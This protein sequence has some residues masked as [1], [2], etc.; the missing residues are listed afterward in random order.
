MSALTRTAFSGEPAAFEYL[1]NTLW[2][3]G[4]V[5]PHCGSI[6]RAT[7][8]QGRNGEGKR[9]ARIGLWKCN[10][11]E[12]RK[13][14]T[15]KVGTVFE[16]GRIPLHKMLQAVYLLCCSKKGISSHQ[17]HRVLGITYK[18]AWFLSHRIRE[19]MRDGSLSPL[20]G[21]GKVVEIDETGFGRV[22]GAPRKAKA[23]M[24]GY[25]RTVLTLVERGGSARSFH[26]DGTTLGQLMPIIRANVNRESAVM[27]DAASWYKNLAF[28]TGIVEHDTV[29]HESEE[30]VRREGEKVITT[31]TVEGYYSI[32]KRGM[33]GVY[34]HCG[35]KHLHR[36]LAEFDFRYSN[37]VALGVDDGARTTRALKGVVGKRLTYLE[38]HRTAT[39]PT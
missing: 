10:E 27:T 7:K 1:E 15:V 39:K 12:C 13:Q 35:E 3:D 19:A 4:A 22:D 28:H 6:G 34:Q 14:F 5:C 36:Y 32:F 37:R 8:L 20:G 31:N 17:L 38:P 30:Y 2:P 11:K 16:H 18:A 9:Q 24:G 25:G 26:V 29:H 21:S 23:I 33:K